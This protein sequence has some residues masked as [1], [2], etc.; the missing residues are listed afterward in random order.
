MLP[1]SAQIIV[2]G[3]SGLT[4]R[5]A[6]HMPNGMLALV[7]EN[8]KVLAISDKAYLL[9]D[10]P[11]QQVIASARKRLAEADAELIT[12]GASLG[13]P[14]IK[15]QAKKMRDAAEVADIIHARQSNTNRKS[16]DRIIGEDSPAFLDGPIVG[17]NQSD[18]QIRART[19]AAAREV[20]DIR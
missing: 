12:L 9:H 15:E 11:A 2:D 14:S 10:E 13:Q 20:P 1:S 19:E 18:T 6:I 8:D 17:L 16:V 7:F 5:G 3:L 4:I